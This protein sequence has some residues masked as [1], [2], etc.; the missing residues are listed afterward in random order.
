MVCPIS[1]SSFRDNL[2]L[3]F[4]CGNEVS[5]SAK[6]W[7]DDKLLNGKF[8]INDKVRDKYAKY[9]QD[10]NDYENWR[11]YQDVFGHSYC[12]EWNKKLKDNK[13]NN[14]AEFL[15][16]V[17]GHPSVRERKRLGRND[18]KWLLS[19]NLTKPEF[20]HKFIFDNSGEYS[21]IGV[22]DIEWLKVEANNDNEQV[23]R[24][25][26][27]YKK[28]LKTCINV[29]RLSAAGIVIFLYFIACHYESKGKVGTIQSN[30]AGLV[31]GSAM[32]ILANLYK[33]QESFWSSKLMLDVFEDKDKERTDLFKSF[34]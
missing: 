13:Y 30:L 8:L 22:D 15:D 12:Q 25:L 28:N 5:L 29:M 2:D 20:E 23:K 6:I 33:T 17:N 7:Y 11:F 4:Q 26:E 24:K 10:L 3:I 9:L 31:K 21:V 18:L 34:M 32:I 14:V 27:S 16:E 1:G 19:Y